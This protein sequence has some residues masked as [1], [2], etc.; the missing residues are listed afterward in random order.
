VG[1]VE[2]ALTTCVDSIHQ[3]EQQGV[4]ASELIRLGECCEEY[5]KAIAGVLKTP[6]HIYI[7]SPQGRCAGAE[8]AANND[9]QL[10]GEARE[11]ATIFASLLSSCMT[12][13]PLNELL[14][15]DVLSAAA[16]VRP[17]SLLDA[18]KIN[19]QSLL[20][21]IQ[22]VYK[23]IILSLYQLNYTKGRHHGG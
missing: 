11:W 7:E 20:N 16:M 10:G 19:T 23:L 3:L 14:N 22:Y 4:S 21:N 15:K 12:V 1:H 18:N 5:T 17:S 9:D 2:A 6:H 8:S 13:L